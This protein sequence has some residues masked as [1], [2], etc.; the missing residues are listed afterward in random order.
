MKK[1]LLAFFAALSM[2]AS[3]SG[4]SDN[5]NSSSSQ[6]SSES[7]ASDTESSRTQADDSSENESDAADT[8]TQPET[9]APTQEPTTTHVSPKETVSSTLGSQ[10]TLDK[11]I[12][13]EDG[14][15]TLKVSLSDLIQ[16]GDSVSSFTFVIYS[17]GGDI[18]TFK[19]GCGISVSDDCPSA[20]DE[21]W[22]QS[23]D[24]SAATE[25]AYGE[26]TWNVP[27]DISQY[28]DASGEVLFGYW[29]G[30]TTSIRVSEVICTYTRTAEI[31]CDGTVNIDVGETVG[32]NDADNSV[33]FS[34]ADAVPDGNVPTA[35]TY[36]IS[37][38]GSL[39]KFTGAFGISC[40]TSDGWYQSGDIA[41]FTDSSSLSLTWIIPDS[42][43]SNVKVGGEAMLGYWWSDQAA[44]TLDSVSVKYA[45][46][47]GSS[48]SS[49]KNVTSTEANNSAAEAT[50]AASASSSDFRSASQIVSDI[51]V[52]WNLGNTL[53]SYNYSEWTT[54]AETAWGNPT[55]TEA[56]IKSVKD[57]GF[58]AIRIPVTWGEHM[59][60]DT[61]DSDWMNR[62][63]EV[64]DYAYNQDMFVILNMHHDDY[65]WFTP[66][67]SEYSADSEKL[68]SI[69]NQICSRFGD[70]GD[71]L[72]FEGMNEPRTVGSSGEW[73]GGT[74]Q[75]RAVINKYEQDFV[76][77]VRASGGNNAQRTLV[78]TSYAA[79][80][81]DAAIN[82]VIVPDD[83]NIIVSI[84]FYAPWQFAN[85]DSNEWDKSV[86]D[87]GFAKLKS[88]FIDNGT[89]VIIGEFGAVANDNDSERA[90][91]YNY[92]ISKAKEN[93]IKCFAWDNGVDSGESAYGL[94]NRS[95]LSWNSSI[96]QGIMNGAN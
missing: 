51:K 28:I 79:S 64:V 17:D 12:Q 68:C 62:V 41:V 96:L 82:D 75:E 54:D 50:A 77:T 47:N 56:M 7:S 10:V 93:G 5:S 49:E 21:G 6:A 32:Y 34:Y 86:L 39:G 78:I 13:R 18:G 72:L 57:A 59:D 88:T 4:C 76:N 45:Y 3:F 48:S 89:P 74:A 91:Y 71:R 90:E 84:H 53:D 52:G 38:N 27:G 24:F 23:D 33:K 81:D 35:I 22:Y 19:G 69:W 73:T 46:K 16:Q 66:D 14:S 67:E 31:S 63:Q 15:N 85:G 40:D 9:E 83:E 60:G 42:V 80:I 37:S 87:E 29:W 61:I 70:Y 44:V 36:N 25:G 58:N 92:Y 43:A 26:I 1:K 2:A 95:T 11:T 94:F 55:T 20:T 30:E 65:I 8:T